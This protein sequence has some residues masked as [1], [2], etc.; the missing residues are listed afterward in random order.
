MDFSAFY[1][2]F[3][4]ENVDWKEL[5]SL[6]QSQII[7][8]LVKTILLLYIYMGVSKSHGTPKSSILIGF[9]IINYKPSI[10]GYP[11]FWKHPYI[12]SMRKV[13]YQPFFQNQRM[14]HLR[15]F[16]VI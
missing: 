8:Q 13:W 11:Y 4:P 5:E 12:Y 2:M 10:L 1:P 15:F 16:E 14:I 7:I 6:F 3:T 9:S